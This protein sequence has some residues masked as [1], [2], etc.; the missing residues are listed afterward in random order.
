[1]LQTVKNADDVVLPGQSR[2]NLRKEASK[3]AVYPT[4]TKGFI[5]RGALVD[6][7]EFC[8]RKDG[9]GEVAE[10]PMTGAYI[11]P[12][13]RLRQSSDG[14]RPVKIIAR[15]CLEKPLRVGRAEAI[16]EIPIIKGQSGQGQPGILEYVTAGGAPI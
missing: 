7:I 3:A 12:T 8:I 11:Q 14:F 2:R 13:C 1:M 4:H 15:T 10:M 9:P 5:D 16:V 6:T